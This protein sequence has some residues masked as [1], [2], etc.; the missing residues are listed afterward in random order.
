LL[1]RRVQEFFEIRQFLIGPQDKRFEA[2]VRANSKVP[3]NPTIVLRPELGPT[4]QTDFS[5]MFAHFNRTFPTIISILNPFIRSRL[6]AG[7]RKV[8]IIAQTGDADEGIGPRLLLKSGEGIG[9]CWENSAG[10]ELTI[11]PEKPLEAFLRLVRYSNDFYF[12]EHP[13]RSENFDR[14]A[15]HALDEAAE[16]LGA[17]PWA[18]VL[19]DNREGF[20]VCTFLW[21]RNPQEQLQKF[22]AGSNPDSFCGG[23]PVSSRMFSRLNDVW[24]AANNAA[25]D[26]KE[27]F[28]LQPELGELCLLTPVQE[29][30]SG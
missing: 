11:F 2:E 13:C 6:A 21:A 29:S 4:R 10:C 14:W 12:E 1:T 22:E 18:A 3:D 25:R 5:L 17:N 8:G 16:L 23:I 30:A 24:F 15:P 19:G 26:P 9:N 27:L 28:L 7:E 20:S